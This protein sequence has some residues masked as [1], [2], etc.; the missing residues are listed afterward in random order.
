MM[1]V[2]DGGTVIG[3]TAVSLAKDR[4]GDISL[5]LPNKTLPKHNKPSKETHA[6]NTGNLEPSL[7]P[8][9]HRARK[10]STQLVRNQLI[11]FVI[12]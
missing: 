1:W 7:Y 10:A 3:M 2:G 11:L 6:T 9:I 12:L 5:R 8:F 4:Q